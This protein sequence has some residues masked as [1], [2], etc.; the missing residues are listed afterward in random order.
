M[1]NLDIEKLG[2]E[3]P[4]K[5]AENTFEIIQNNV[6]KKTLRRKQTPI[7]NL[8]W[9]YATAA[10]IL[11][12]VGANFLINTNIKKDNS[13]NHKLAAQNEIGQ[14][15]ISS[16]QT[17]VD[18]GNEMAGNASDLSNNDISDATDL[19]S[20][21]FTHLSNKEQIQNSARLA[22]S[23]KVKSNEPTEA[24]IDEVLDGF[25]SAEITLLSNNTEQ[26]VY[27]DLYN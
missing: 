15:Q 4:Y 7:F 20:T 13:G 14:Q 9:L 23:S 21:K 18:Q 27:L 12:I 11:L 1:E 3:M 26:D 22:N 5:L 25:S 2:R 8:K 17:F 6:I 16:A 24:K 19:T 10:V